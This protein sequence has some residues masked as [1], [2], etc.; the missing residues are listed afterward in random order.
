MYMCIPAR[1]RSWVPL[2]VRSSLK[3][4]GTTPIFQLQAA[5]TKKANQAGIY[6]ADTFVTMLLWM[7]E[8]LHHV[9]SPGMII[10]L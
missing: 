8:I 9:R 6:P 2:K 5:Q 1:V 3:G 4:S 7:D 10:S